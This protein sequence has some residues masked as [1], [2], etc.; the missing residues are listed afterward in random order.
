M[1]QNIEIKTIQTFSVAGGLAKSKGVFTCTHYVL[2][3]WKRVLNRL[4]VRD[5][6]KSTNEQVCVIQISS[7]VIRV[8]LTNV[9]NQD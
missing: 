6:G 9:A 7:P 3:H 4:S 8:V 2:E 1:G 5:W